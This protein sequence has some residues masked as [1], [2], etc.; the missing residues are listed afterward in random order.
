MRSGSAFNVQREIA[1]HAAQPGTWATAASSF[2]P[3]RL[4]QIPDQYLS[5]GGQLLT[6]SRTLFGIVTTGPNL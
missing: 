4:G 5:L 3:F 1:R 6:R 2:E